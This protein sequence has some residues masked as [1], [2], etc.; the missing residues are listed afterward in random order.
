MVLWPELFTTRRAHVRVTDEGFTV[1]DE[2]REPNCEIGMT[3]N[4]EEFIKRIM[5]RYL[6]QNL[7]RW[8]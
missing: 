6:K 2:S 5:D 8:N 7:Q 4:R 1:V 3:I